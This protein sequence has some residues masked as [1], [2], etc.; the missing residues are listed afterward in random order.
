MSFL[1]GQQRLRLWVISMAI[2]SVLWLLLPQSAHAADSGLNGGDGASEPSE[3]ASVE[4]WKR[5]IATD[6]SDPTAWNN[7]GQKLFATE[8]Y[9]GALMAYNHALLINPDYSLVLA[10]RCGVLSR[11]EEYAQALNSCN[12][13]IK[14]DGHWSSQGSALAW[15]NR[16]DVL[17]NLENYQ[18][19]LRSFEQAIIVNP[20]YQ[21]AWYNRAVV[22]SQLDSVEK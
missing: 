2:A 1:I 10:N 17:F 20:N 15:S 13:A 18:A 14:G 12:L 8:Q 22:L 5:A 3:Q 16:G 19:A 21:N 4:A 9:E 11:L 6:P 7:L